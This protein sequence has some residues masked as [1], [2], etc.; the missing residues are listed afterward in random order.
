MKSIERRQ[1]KRKHKGKLHRGRISAHQLNTRNADRCES[2]QCG[3]SYRRRK[4]K[5]D[6][7][8]VTRV[9]PNGS[10]MEECDEREEEEEEEE[11]DEEVG[12]VDRIGAGVNS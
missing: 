4:G 6:N 5:I 7:R 9:D 1:I 8:P 2:Y 11:E 10:R 3:V 12:G